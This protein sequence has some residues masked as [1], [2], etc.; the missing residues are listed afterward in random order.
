M[1]ENSR[2]NCRKKE[3][4]PLDGNCLVSDLVYQADVITENRDIEHIMTYFGQTGREFKSRYYE[5]R[6]AFK[7]KNSKMATALSNYVHKL[8]EEGKE[9][10][11]K[12]SIKSRAL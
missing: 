7:N 6:M 4:C 5:H 8:K 9:F 12:W 1:Q 10:T 3:E 11:I 2:C